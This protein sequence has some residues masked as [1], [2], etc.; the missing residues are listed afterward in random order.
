M[1]AKFRMFIYVA[2]RVITVVLAAIVEISKIVNATKE[3]NSFTSA[4]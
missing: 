2:I 1:F 3:N 4:V